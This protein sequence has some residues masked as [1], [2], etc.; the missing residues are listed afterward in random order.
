MG[1]GAGFARGLPELKDGASAVLLAIED[2]E[3]GGK[4]ELSGFNS[5]K[6]ADINSI[7][8]TNV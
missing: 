1:W 5:F 4:R 8:I 3:M 6:M 2:E 7:G